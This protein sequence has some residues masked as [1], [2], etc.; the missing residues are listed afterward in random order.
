M[1]SNGE[2]VSIWWRHKNTL[3]YIYQIKS[4]WYTIRFNVFFRLVRSSWNIFVCFY[5]DPRPESSVTW[6]DVSGRSGVPWFSR[7]RHGP[8]T[9]YVKLRIALLISNETAISDPGMHP[10]TCVTHVLRCMSGS[11]ISGGGENVPGIPG[12]CATRNFTYLARGS[13]HGLFSELLTLC[14]RSRNH[15]FRCSPLLSRLHIV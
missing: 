6:G 9:R 3:H 13:W 8:L 2:D 11:L 14:E 4:V 10:G 15:N 7:R 1:A 5:W 12:A